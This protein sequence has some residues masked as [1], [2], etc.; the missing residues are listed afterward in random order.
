MKKIMW[1]LITFAVLGYCILVYSWIQ[2]GNRRF[3]N[4]RQEVEQQK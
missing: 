3:E 4:L 2:E 1:A